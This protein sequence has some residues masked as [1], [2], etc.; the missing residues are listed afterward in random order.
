MGEGQ[1]QNCGPCAPLSGPG[2]EGVGPTGS[3]RLPPAPAPE[4]LQVTVTLWRF[5]PDALWLADS[6]VAGGAQAVAL[7][8]LV[9]GHGAQP[10]AVEAQCGM[11]HLRWGATV[12]LCKDTEA[13]SCTV[14]HLPEAPP[15]ASP[16][17]L[18][19]CSAWNP[20]SPHSPP[21]VKVP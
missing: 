4:G 13:L 2:E 10:S 1:G 3:A 7:V 9:E 20:C 8:T 16:S 5:A 11:L 14:G 17:A 12:H 6:D 15:S 19:G 21:R 18:P